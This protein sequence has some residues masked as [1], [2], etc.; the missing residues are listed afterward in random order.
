[1]ARWRVEQQVAQVQGRHLFLR[2]VWQRFAENA[3]DARETRVLE[4]RKQ[5]AWAKARVWLSK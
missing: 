3:A 4:A 1:M 5:E 2:H